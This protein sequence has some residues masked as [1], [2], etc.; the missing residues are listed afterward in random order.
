VIIPQLAIVSGI[1][2]SLMLSFPLAW[3]WTLWPVCN[4]RNHH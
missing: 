2:R 4:S 1:I 3:Y